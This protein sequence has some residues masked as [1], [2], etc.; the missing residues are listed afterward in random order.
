M[1]KLLLFIGL[2][3]TA[4]AN[5][6][7][8]PGQLL[9]AGELNA[10]FALYAPLAG[11]TFAGP[12]T[13]PT[14][15]VST[16]ATLPTQAAN[17]LLGN[18][19]GSSAS[20]T[21]IS[22]GGCSS[23]SSALSYTSGAGFGCNSSVNAATLGG[24]T[25]AAPGPIGSTTPSTG[26]FTNLSS[27]GTLTLPNG[28]V[29]LPYLATEAS[30]TVVAN[31]TGSTASPVAFSM[32]SCT[33]SSNALGYTS[34]TGIVCNGA[35]NA[36]TLGGTAAASYALLAS[37]TFTG[38][39]AAPTAS[40][41]TNTTQIAT[42]AMVNSAVTGGNLAGS[43]TTLSA[44][45]SASSGATETVSATSNT[46]NGATIRLAGNGGTTPNKDIRAFNGQF[47]IVNSAV[48]SIIASVDDS[49]NLVVAGSVTPSQT[50]GLVGTT[51]NN[52]ANAGSVG[53]YISSTVASGSSISLSSGVSA[54]V[55]SISLTAGDWDVFGAVQFTAGATTTQTAYYGCIST[56][57]ATLIGGQTAVTPGL[58]TGQALAGVGAPQIRL[59]LASTTTV[60]LVAESIFGTSTMNAYG[61]IGARR[62][63]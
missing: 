39:P 48:N 43:F 60:Y 36:S 41:T 25:F 17:T 10:Q 33:G 54:N 26:S 62:R 46:G 3:W 8:T 32:P 28:S 12:V 34:G 21:A 44:T 7:F 31:F 57:S 4:S 14:L 16:T 15:T 1:K 61:F 53:E 59:S 50:G 5:A 51:T 56:V 49:G 45:S 23:S 37:P 42:T 35:I 58:A 2:L 18:T 9:T 29:T 24:A 20:P 19:S 27:N 11:A 38:T 6:Q 13:I 52:N 63:R 40:A 22:V 55:T 47:Q 30:N